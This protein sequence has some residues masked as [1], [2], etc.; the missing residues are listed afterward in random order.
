MKKISN[1]FNFLNK[2]EFFDLKI[3][4]EANGFFSCSPEFEF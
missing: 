3:K 1:S 4:I 2:S